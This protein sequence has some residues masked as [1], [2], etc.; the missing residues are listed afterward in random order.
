[1]VFMKIVVMTYKKL[2]K[3]YREFCEF[4]KKK[5]IED[6]KEWF[7]TED[8]KITDKQRAEFFEM[9]TK[10]TFVEFWSYVR[11]IIF[12]KN[13]FDLIEKTDNESWDLASI[14]TF[15]VKKKIVKVTGSGKAI[16]LDKDLKKYLLP[17]YTREQI[18]KIIAK[19]LG[20]K[21]I[22]KM[23]RKPVSELAKKIAGKDFSY[24]PNYDQMPISVDSAIN[25][26][27]RILDK[28][29][30]YDGF[31]FVGD[32]DFMSIVLSL[33]VPKFSS[34]VIDIDENLLD[35]ISSLAKRI[36]AR[37]K[38]MKVDIRSN[39]KIADNIMGFLMNP[40]YTAK[41]VMFFVRFGI[42]QFSE[43]GGYGFVIFGDETIGKRKL[44]IQEFFTKNNLVLEEIV[45]GKIGYPSNEL[46]AE[47]VKE[48]REIQHLG[49]SSKVIKKHYQLAAFLYVLKY[50]PW[51]IKKINIKGM[52]IY[53][54]I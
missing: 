43:K 2:E 3:L 48:L 4:Q 54:Y 9:Y 36:N 7:G 49:V 38:T 17:L 25:V 51:K 26:A 47:D 37:I 11:R 14:L 52:K 39:K 22:K 34:T 8:L 32:D 46:H 15:L 53:S 20:L 35:Y 41:G 6:S 28:Y 24:N 10:Y 27:E 1:M 5:Y 45:N 21:N 31:L 13:V 50:V 19:K 29:P 42:K 23:L 18:E 40:P 44:F 33:I 12:G 30:F 16:L